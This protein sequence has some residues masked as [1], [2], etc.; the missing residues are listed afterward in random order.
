MRRMTGGFGDGWTPAAV[1]R[2]G[3]SKMVRFKARR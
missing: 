3:R 1:R 2:V